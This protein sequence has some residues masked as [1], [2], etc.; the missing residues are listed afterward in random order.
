MLSLFIT[1]TNNELIKSK[2][3]ETCC[4]RQLDQL[5]LQFNSSQ[6]RAL[7]VLTVIGLL[8]L[9]IGNSSSAVRSCGPEILL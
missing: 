5:K 7:N 4:V 6:N 3:M 9:T 1:I 8:F 2:V